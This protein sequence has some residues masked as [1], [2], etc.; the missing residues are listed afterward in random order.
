MPG[1]GG[2]WGCIGQAGWK[3]KADSY[4]TRK[5]AGRFLG[6]AEETEKVRGQETQGLKKA[7]VGAKGQEDTENKVSTAGVEDS[8]TN[9]SKVRGGC[10]SE[11]WSRGEL[12]CKQLS[13]GRSWRV[14]RNLSS[15]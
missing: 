7:V 1:E 6:P 3:A 4:N 10:G 12:C 2:G 15:R 9:Q 8:R 14:T 11:N 13:V 5:M